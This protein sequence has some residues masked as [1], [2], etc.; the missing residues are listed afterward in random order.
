MDRKF[1]QF[2]GPS[3]F[4]ERLVDDLREGKNIVVCLPRHAPS[5]LAATV[6]SVL[7]D[8]FDAPWQTM[9]LNGEASEPPATFLARRMLH[10]SLSTSII[11]AASLVSEEAFSGRIL[12]LDGM[13]SE[14]WP[15]WQCF[16]AEYSHICQSLPVLDRT[17]LC[18]PLEGELAESPPPVD[19]CLACHEWRGIVDSLDA[20][21][22]SSQLLRNHSLPPLRKRVLSAIGSQLAL[23]DPAVTL[24]LIEAGTEAFFEPYPI[25]K[26]IAAERDWSE[27]SLDDPEYRWS[28][29][30]MDVFDGRELIHSAAVALNDTDKE[31]VRRIWCA[32]VGVLLPY[33]EQER[34]VILKELQGVL[35]V[36]F[37]TRFGDTITDWRDLEI[38]HIECQV[39][40]ANIA[41]PGKTR[42]H[43]RHLL[44]IRNRLAH[45][46]V[47]PLNL[48]F[49]N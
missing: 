23:W 25:L 37:E 26:A 13:S 16:L 15:P 34:Q 12:W 14:A 9:D 7:D 35:R 40:E 36:P 45:Q 33:V 21:L 5:R 47:V 49:N 28:K 17:L 19:V 46:E 6:R 44:K 10:N 30:Q 39:S 48:L 2:G 18:I 31:I 24:R 43:L 38:G 3:R 42:R 11:N 1:W 4:V 22:F 32:Q 29:G 27:Q 41:I 8:S 20:L